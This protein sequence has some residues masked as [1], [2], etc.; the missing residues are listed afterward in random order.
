VAA[1][2]SPMNKSWQAL[3]EEYLQL[4]E[5][6]GVARAAP[7]SEVQLS[8]L[9]RVAGEHK[10]H[11][12]H[13]VYS[14]LRLTNGTGFD[15]LRFYGVGIEEDDSLGR[16]DLL[17]VN[18]LVEER[19]EDTLYGEWQDEFFVHVRENGTFA[20]RSIATWDI[21]FEYDTYSELV[22]AVLDEELQLLRPK[23]QQ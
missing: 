2:I 8:E 3:L 23:V 6:V 22:S 5:Q 18:D 19:G 16:M 20:R 17:E 14:F 7:A 15:S 12:D 13:V 21:L 1:E 4:G 11:W 10:V 9:R